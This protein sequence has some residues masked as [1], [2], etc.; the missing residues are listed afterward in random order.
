MVKIK[1][2]FLAILIML[3]IPNTIT[4]PGRPIVIVPINLTMDNYIKYNGYKILHPKKY[5]L[6]K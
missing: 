5:L 6:N 2:I 4:M 1:L 3:G